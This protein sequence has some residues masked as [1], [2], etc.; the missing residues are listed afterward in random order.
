M[1]RGKFL[2]GF[3]GVVSLSSWGKIE[4]KVWTLFSGV[5]VWGSACHTFRV[6]CGFLLK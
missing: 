5:G 4:S 6:T 1:V 3:G 2:G